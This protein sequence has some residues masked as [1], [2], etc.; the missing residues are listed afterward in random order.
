[1]KTNN[2]SLKNFLFINRKLAYPF[3]FVY[4]IVHLDVFSFRTGSFTMENGSFAQFWEKRKE[5]KIQFTLPIDQLTN[6]SDIAKLVE[7]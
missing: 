2:N 6:N 7:R 1:M 4:L 3:R 5:S